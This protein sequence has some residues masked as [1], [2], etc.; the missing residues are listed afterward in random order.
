MP[1]T[2]QEFATFA[3]D[4]AT[5]YSIN[6]FKIYSYTKQQVLRNNNCN[7][8]TTPHHCNPIQP[9]RAPEALC[10]KRIDLFF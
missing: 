7:I 9:N 3:T 10:A 1:L 2:N 5:I 8:Y 4:R 6:L